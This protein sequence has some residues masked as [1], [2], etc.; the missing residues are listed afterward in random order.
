MKNEKK[1][2]R[3]KMCF[4][5]SCIEKRIRFILRLCELEIYNVLGIERHVGID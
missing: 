3:V 4:A 5:F 1:K 2:R